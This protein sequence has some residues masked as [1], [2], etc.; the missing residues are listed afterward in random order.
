MAGETVEEHAVTQVLY[1]RDCG[2]Q[3]SLGIHDLPVVQSTHTHGHGAQ[4]LLRT[5]VLN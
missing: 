5:F 3:G 2:Q 1:V 4:S